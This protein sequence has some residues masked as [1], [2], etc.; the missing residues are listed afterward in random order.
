MSF[1]HKSIRKAL[2]SAPSQNATIIDLAGCIISAVLSEAFWPKL[3]DALEQPQLA[4]DPRY[5]TLAK[6]REHRA[7]LECT[8]A[9]ITMTRTVREWEQQLAAHDVPHAPI[10]NI[11]EALAHPHAAARNMVVTAKHRDIGEI[12]M[13]GRPVKF[14][15]SPQAPLAAAPVL[16]Q[17]TISILRDLLGCSEDE[18]GRLANSGAI[19]VPPD[20]MPKKRS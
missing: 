1:V 9:K 7:A 8:I 3:C 5:S 13:T 18:L 2:L 14:P 12:R 11:G 6:R 10:L 20:E 17:D 15:G 4:T 16:G 19:G